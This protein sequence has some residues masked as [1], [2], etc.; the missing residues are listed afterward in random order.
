VRYAALLAAV[1]ALVALPAAGRDA[2]LCRPIRGAGVLWQNPA[3][4]FILV[5]E[6]HGTA[7][8][9]AI[10]GDLVCIA[11]TATHR[12]I[13]AAIEHPVSEQPALDAFLRSSGDVKAQDALRAQDTWT[14]FQDGRE[15]EAYFALIEYLRGLKAAHRITRVVA[16]DPAGG[17]RDAVMAQNLMTASQAVP[18]SLTLVFT[19]NVHAAKV[20]PDPHFQQ[21]AASMLPLAVTISLVVAMK[22]GLAWD[23]ESTCG[24]HR[25]GPDSSLARGVFV[26]TAWLKGYDGTLSTGTPATPSLPAVR[27][28]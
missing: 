1:L 26:G 7:E 13:I 2:G 21:G 5:G 4:R 9:P 16:F 20:P 25:M 10:F 11:A 18:S 14:G 23:C 27:Q 6:I 12:P 15:S 24:P 22:R 8:S 28:R 3:V 17:D 19:G